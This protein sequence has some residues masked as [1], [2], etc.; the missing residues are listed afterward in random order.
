MGHKFC[1]LT[2]TDRYRIEALIRAKQKPRQIAQ[3]LHVHASTIYRELKRART[4]FRNRDW[5]EEERYNPDLAEARYRM[6]LSAK[7]GA[8]KLAN[9]YEFANYIENKII[10]GHLSPAAALASIKLE[11]KAFKTHICRVTL[12]SYI[13]KG[14]FLNL[15][16]K[17][18]PIKGKRKQKYRK[19]SVIK[20][21]PRGESIEKRPAEVL[22]RETFGHWEGDTVYSAKK[23]AQDVLFVFTERRTRKELILKMPNRTAASGV[24]ALD[25]LEERYGERFTEI[26]RSITF[27]NGMEFADTEALE[28]SRNGRR[29]TKVYY[30]HPYSSYERGSN[31]NQNLLIRRIYPKGTDFSQLTDADVKRLE[32]WINSYPRKLLG[33]KTADMLFAQL[34]GTA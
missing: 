30:C 8:L 10:D 19:V 33:W 26:F 34:A 28:H 23:S 3:Q 25:R 14:Y 9:D 21:A 4:V 27:D 12:Y 15:T 2:K 18:L 32:D 24:A 6:N 7:G 1:H 5:T 11:G 17:H 31:E 16:N 20:R 29:R 13:D 22:E